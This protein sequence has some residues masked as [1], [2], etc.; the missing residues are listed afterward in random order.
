LKTIW[1]L[2]N[3]KGKSSFYNKFDL[4][5]MFASVIQWRKHHPN[6][7][8]ELYAD[9]LTLD[10]FQSLGALKLWDDHQLVKVNAAVNKSI[11]WASSKL[12]TLRFI[13]EPVIIMDN[14]F[15]VYQSFNKFI[16]DRPVVAHNENGMGYY[17]TTSDFFIKKVKHLIN[18]PTTDAINCSFLYFPDAKFANTYAKIS[19]E[20]MEVFT[21]AKAPNSKY[22]IFAE[23]LLLKNLFTL[24]NIQYDSL[25]DS[26]Y[27]CTSNKFDEHTKG[28]IPIQDAHLYYR[29]YWKEKVK[30]R[31]N[32]DGFS[33]E[34]EVEQLE[35]VVK[36][37]ILVDWSIL[38]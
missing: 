18:R 4:L 22:L 35:N 12:Q 29:H 26:I 5:M 23:Q 32:E 30:I 33:Y 19:L 25:I 16:K 20:M 10:L 14:D 17:L 8:C 27:N 37:H 34:K 15:I 7:F 31:N 2:E 13:K 38:C 21:R 9:Q 3:I 1:V 36:N 6:L 28:L 11:F 24:Y